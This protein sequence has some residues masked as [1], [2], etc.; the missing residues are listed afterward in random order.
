MNEAD[1]LGMQGLPGADWRSSCRTN[2]RYLLKDGA[3]YDLVA[4]V[5]VIVE[6]RVANMLHMHPDLVG[7]AFRARIA[8]V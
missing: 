7:A 5:G 4:A 3:F 6:Q 2:C 1:G 8:R